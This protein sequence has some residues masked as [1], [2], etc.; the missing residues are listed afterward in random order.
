[1][2]VTLTKIPGL[3]IFEP[4]RVGDRRGFLAELFNALTLCRVRNFAGRSCRTTYVGVQP[5]GVLRGIAPAK[6]QY[7]GQARHRI[8]GAPF[9][10]RQSMCVSAAPH[11]ASTSSS[12]FRTKTAG[13][14][15]LLSVLPTDLSYF[16]KRRIF[17]ISAM[18]S[19]PRDELVVRW[20]D[21]ALGIDWRLPDPLLN[22]R[23]AAAPCLADVVGLPHYDA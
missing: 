14:F 5:R 4:A 22:A 21:P 10:T 11:S 9:S 15:I 23:D 6:S 12:S 7:A 20:N 18:I 16:R 1:M 3:L 13:I 2:K 8:A 19:R 17:Y